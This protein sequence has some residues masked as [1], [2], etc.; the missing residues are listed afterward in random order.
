MLVKGT[1]LISAQGEDNPINEDEKLVFKNC[2]P[3]NDSISEIK[4]DK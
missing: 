3:F 4:I 1:I 2:A